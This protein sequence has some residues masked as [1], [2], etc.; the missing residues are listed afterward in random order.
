MKRRVLIV[1]LINYRSES[2]ARLG[3]VNK[4][5]QEF[6]YVYVEPRKILNGGVL[7]CHIE[8]LLVDTLP[9]D[10]WEADVRQPPEDIV[11]F[12]DVLP[13]G[14]TPQLAGTL[15]W[16]GFGNCNC[17]GRRERDQL[18]VLHSIWAQD[19]IDAAIHL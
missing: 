5:A 11:T 3:P 13:Y 18:Q 16:A 19:E 1:K 8:R 17:L 15:A 9:A 12:R 2:G 6:Y 10:D 14:L 4:M 7:E